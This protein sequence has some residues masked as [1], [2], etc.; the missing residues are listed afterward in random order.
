[1]KNLFQN[2]ELKI[3]ADAVI[4]FFEKPDYIFLKTE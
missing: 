1:M 3:Q 2:K 4:E